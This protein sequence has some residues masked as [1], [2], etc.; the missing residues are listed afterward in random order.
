MA[1]KNL[2]FLNNKTQKLDESKNYSW[3]KYAFIKRPE[4]FLPNKCQFTIKAK[5]CHVIDLDNKKYLDMSSMALGHV[6]WVIQIQRL[7]SQ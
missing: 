6:F 3:W 2:K 4:M 1:K 7:I 5:G